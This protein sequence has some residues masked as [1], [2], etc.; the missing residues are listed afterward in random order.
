MVNLNIKSQ[1]AQI[2]SDGGSISYKNVAILWY[3]NSSKK[4]KTCNTDKSYVRIIKIIVTHNQMRP[5]ELDMI[6]C[7]EKQQI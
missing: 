7:A 5:R 2:K 3:Y 1:L 4:K 6:S